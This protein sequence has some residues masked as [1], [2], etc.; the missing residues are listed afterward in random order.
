M[1]RRLIRP[2]IT[3]GDDSNEGPAQAARPDPRSHHHAPGG[4]LVGLRERRCRVDHR[5]LK[6]RAGASWEAPPRWKLLPTAVGRSPPPAC[7]RAPAACLGEWC[8]AG[9]ARKRRAARYG[10]A[11]PAGV[12]PS[13]AAGATLRGRKRRSFEPGW[14]S[15]DRSS[16]AFAGLA[17]RRHATRRPRRTTEAARTWSKAPAT[18]SRTLASSAN[19]WGAPTGKCLKSNIKVTFPMRR[20]RIRCSLPRRRGRHLGHIWGPG[21]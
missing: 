21:R 13:R 1:E 3:Q 18:A 14:A 19:G 10:E 6:L 11:M 8:G 20:G 12:L 2:Q 4:D 17:R 9:R 15:R 7:L 16:V 5:T